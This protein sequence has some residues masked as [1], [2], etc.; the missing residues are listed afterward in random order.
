MRTFAAVRDTGDSA[1]DTLG[2][3]SA[4][5]RRLTQQRNE[6]LQARLQQAAVVEEAAAMVMVAA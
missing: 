5:N 6:L 4:E 3:L 2:K 1:R